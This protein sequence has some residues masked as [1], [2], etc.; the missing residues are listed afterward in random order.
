MLQHAFLPCLHMRTPARTHARTHTRTHTH[1][2]VLSR[3][4]A[5]SE[6]ITAL[7]PNPCPMH[8]C[9]L[10]SCREDR[11]KEEMEKFRQERPK[12]SQQFSDLKR[13]LG[14]V[15]KD[16]WDSLP[17]TGSIRKKRLKTTSTRPDRYT[18][19]PDSVIER[20]ASMGGVTASLDAKQ[21]VR[22]VS[23]CVLVICARSV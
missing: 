23:T 5:S 10:S 7:I 18:P 19:V 14:E 22:N 1:T 9:L 6:L 17:E 16:Q 20:S 12:I 11:I 2:L 13:G 15:T 21:Q 4:V 3:R 8:G